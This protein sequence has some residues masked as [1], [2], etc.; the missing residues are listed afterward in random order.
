ME[1]N[2]WFT[3]GLRKIAEHPAVRFLGNCAI[4]LLIGLLSFM[5]AYAGYLVYQIF[6]EAHK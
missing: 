5:V 4:G 2:D 1:N 3:G 6:A